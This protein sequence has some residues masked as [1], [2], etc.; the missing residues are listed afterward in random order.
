MSSIAPATAASPRLRWQQLVRPG[1]IKWLILALVLVTFAP[2]CRHPFV[3]WDDD[4]TIEH[5]PLILQPTLEHTLH[6]WKHQYMDLYVPVTY[7]VWS[8]LAKLT[9]LIGRSGPDDPLDSTLFHAA[10]VLFHVTN[11]LLV[12]WLL[13]RL[14]K[15]PWPAAA[16][17]M[18][19]ALHPVQVETVAWASGLKDVLCATFSLLALT[20]YLLAVAPAE[21]SEPERGRLRRRFHYVAGMAAMMLGM[22]SKP[23]AMVTPAL[24]LVIDLLILRRPWRQVLISV[25]PWF[26]LAAPCI[27]WTKICQPPRFLKYIPI[28]QRPLVAADALAFYLYKL[29]LP[30]NM[31]FDYGRPPWV[32]FERGFAF[33]TWLVPAAIAVALIIYRKRTGPLAAGALLMIVG[34]APVLGLTVFDYEMIST[35]A[36]HYLYLA[37]LGPALAAAWALSRWKLETERAVTVTVIILGLFAARAAHQARYWESSEA[38]FTHA[39]EIS[40][41]SW[42]VHYEMGFLVHNQA[43]LPLAMARIQEEQKQDATQA[44]LTAKSL[45]LRAMDEYNQTLKLNPRSVSARHGRALIL[46]H[47]GRYQEAADGFA[48][49]LRWRYVLPPEGRSQF[50]QDIDLLGQC[51]YNLGRYPQAVK[52][53]ETAARIQPPIPGVAERLKTAQAALKVKPTRQV[54][55]DTQKERIDSATGGN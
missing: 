55:T 24:A 28:W 31:A 7:T 3:D 52:A 23:T 1:W 2:I 38:L 18:L 30:A 29:L 4:Y 5:N 25:A 6:Y 8:G 46:M 54:L 26:A 16:G 22:L 10:S 51:L 48:D 44:V 9:R 14:I 34:V 45:L 12:Y 40:P 11:A 19:F 20:Q 21:A 50:N 53:F 42:N 37:M 17:A 47:F 35:V 32:V 15:R 43:T 27:V 39:L 41:G 49:V 33:W 13:T 36:D